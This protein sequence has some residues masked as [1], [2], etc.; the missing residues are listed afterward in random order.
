MSPRPDMP[1]VPTLRT[2]RLTLR[3][4]ALED[5]EPLVAFYASDRARFIGGPSDRDMTWRGLLAQIGHW[6]VRGY[7][8][9]SVDT[10]AGEM[11]GRVG[12]VCHESWPE[13][14]LGWHVFA[15]AEGH[16]YALEAAEAARDHAAGLGLGPLISMINPEN[17]RSIRLAE[18]LGAALEREWEHPKWGRTLIFRHPAGKTPP[19]ACEP[20]AIQTLNVAIGGAP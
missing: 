3:A 20:D 16:G 18:R 6:A 5:F 11:I 10:H 9:F 4:P 14:E 8:Y 17:A 19:P 13:P 7:G 12:V 1:R 15:G 2:A